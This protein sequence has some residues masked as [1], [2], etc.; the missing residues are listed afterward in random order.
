MTAPP[1]I[2][3]ETI[4]ERWE[5]WGR[6]QHLCAR[7]LDSHGETFDA[8]LKR[9]RGDVRMAAA[10]ML[11]STSDLP[12]CAKNMMKHAGGSAVRMAPLINFDFAAV[13]Y[14][15]ARTWQSCARELNPELPE[16]QPKWT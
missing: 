14:T 4:A 8:Q 6:S 13:R 15:Q 5:E 9:A 11:R 12:A 3:T 7:V 10:G 16:V 2:D 1:T